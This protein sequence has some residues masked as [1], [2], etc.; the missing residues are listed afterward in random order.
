MRYKCIGN[1]QCLKTFEH[2][3]ALRA[4][5]GACIEAQR[6]LKLKDKI[7]KL[8]QNIGVDYSGIHGLHTNTYY[9]TSHDTDQTNKFQFKDRFKFSGSTSKTDLYNNQEQL[10]PQ[11]MKTVLN[12]HKS[13]QVQQVLTFEN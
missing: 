13:N 1:P 7:E 4:H 5:I 9:P 6:I 11:R 8:E 12:L 2:G 10:R 3:H